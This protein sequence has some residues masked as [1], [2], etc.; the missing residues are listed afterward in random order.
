MNNM[1]LHILGSQFHIEAKD[2]AEVTVRL[3]TF[4]LCCIIVHVHF[5]AL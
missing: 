3:R 5:Q 2:E 1:S 4:S